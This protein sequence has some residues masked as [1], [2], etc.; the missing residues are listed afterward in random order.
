VNECIHELDPPTCSICNG[1]DRRSQRVETRP[2]A[3]IES[4]FD[5]RCD[6]CDRRIQVGDSIGLSEGSWLHVS[7]FGDEL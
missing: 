1:R 7:H 4:R 2:E 5:S 6:Y 3:V